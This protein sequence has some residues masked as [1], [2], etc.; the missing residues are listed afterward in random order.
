MLW[1]RNQRLTFIFFLFFAL[2]VYVLTSLSLLNNV[3][4][5]H[6]NPGQELVGSPIDN[7]VVNMESLP[8]NKDLN[9]QNY[10]LQNLKQRGMSPDQSISLLKKM[11]YI[12]DH[13]W[14]SKQYLL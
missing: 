11:G 13:T 6:T 2:L 8:F 12:Q 5:P 3:N 14:D 10:N 4:L 7:E 1:K 9:K